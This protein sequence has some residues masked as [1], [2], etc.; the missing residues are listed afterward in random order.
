MNRTIT[1]TLAIAFGACVQHARAVEQDKKLHVAA[2]A[3]VAAGVTLLTERPVLGAAAGCLV[4]V[5]KEEYDRRNPPHVAERADAVA[6]CAGAAVGASAGW[7]VLPRRDG[8]A[9]GR[10][11][12][13]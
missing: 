1:L 3:A 7:L 4:G 5:L 11:W 8:V 10:V 9:V 6:T 2:G 13:W 12:S